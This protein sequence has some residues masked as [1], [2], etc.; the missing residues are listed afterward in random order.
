M[1]TS[2]RRSSS[3]PCA[4]RRSG[5]SAGRSRSGGPPPATPTFPHEIRPVV[6]D[7][8]PRPTTVARR[9]DLFAGHVFDGPA[10]IVEDTATTVIPPG[11]TVSVDDIGTLLIRRKDI[12]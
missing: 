8:E 10:V 12:K 9:D 6:F 5:T 1:P 11:Y 4:P 7:G 3:S 2:A